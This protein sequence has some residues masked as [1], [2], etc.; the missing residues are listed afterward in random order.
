MAIWAGIALLRGIVEEAGEV[1]SVLGAEPLDRVPHSPAGH[2]TGVGGLLLVAGVSYGEDEAAAL[3]VLRQPV[4][5]LA[6]AAEQDGLGGVGDGEAG[7]KVVRCQ[8]HE[9]IA[10]LAALFPSCPGEGPVPS[11]AQHAQTFAG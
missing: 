11:H 1:E 8:R 10:L 3:V 5:G 4:G 2:T 6:K 7:S 9:A